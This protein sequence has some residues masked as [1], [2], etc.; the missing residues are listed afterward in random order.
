MESKW[1]S[2]EDIQLNKLYN[3]ESLEIMDISN[4]MN[5]TPGAVIT[6]L[7]KY[8]YIP[9][10]SSARGYLTY[11]NS[12]LYKSIV[13][14]GKYKK[15]E[16]TKTEPNQNDQ[17]QSDIL[18]IKNEIGQLKERLTELVELLKSEN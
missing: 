5:K 13:E 8:G 17:L 2:E 11:K 7:C 10:R 4:R 9:N 1:S 3:E 15:T 18:W 12:D 16:Q 6:R 14:S